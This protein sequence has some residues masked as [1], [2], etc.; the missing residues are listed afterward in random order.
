[1][2]SLFRTP[3]KRAVLVVLL[4]GLAGAVA[5]RL[6]F[7]GEDDRV[8][9]KT[10]AKAEQIRSDGLDY[11]PPENNVPDRAEAKGLGESAHPTRQPKPND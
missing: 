1:M 5:A 11:A 6:V 4:V 2:G 7:H 10:A 9:P 3:G 8:D